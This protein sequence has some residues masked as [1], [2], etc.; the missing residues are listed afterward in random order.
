MGSSTMVLLSKNP[1]ISYLEPTDYFFSYK[2]TIKLGFK[3]PS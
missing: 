3:F 2:I 1:S